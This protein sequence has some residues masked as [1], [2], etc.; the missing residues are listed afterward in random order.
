MLPTDQVKAL[1]GLVYEIKRVPP[2]GESSVR[3]GRKQEVGEC[4]RRDAGGDGGEQ[5]AL[6]R[7]TMAHLVQRR[8][9]IRSARER[10]TPPPWRLAVA[11]SR[12]A[13]RAVEQGEIGPM[14]CRIVAPEDGPN[15]DFAVTHLGGT[16]RDIICPQ[17]KGTAAREIE[18]DVVPMAGQGAGLD[19]AAIQRKSHMRAAMSSAKT[20]PLSWR[21]SIGR[22]GPCT[23]SRPFAFNSSRLPARTKP[24]V[25]VC[26]N[27]LPR[28]RH[29]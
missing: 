17:I 14:R 18:A 2:V 6:G 24:V 26:M 19:A 9:E 7:L 23:T 20:R 10:S 3:V 29:C 5:S 22:C 28:N 27:Y 4:G 16:G 13:A 21:S 15:P 25:G 8:G 1:E 12:N 11:I